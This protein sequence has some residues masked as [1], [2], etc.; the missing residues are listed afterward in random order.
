[1]AASTHNNRPPPPADDD[2]INSSQ[3]LLVNVSWRSVRQKPKR[4]G[5]FK[6]HAIAASTAAPQMMD[7]KHEKLNMKIEQ[8]KQFNVL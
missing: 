3:L 5:A 7:K 6:F 4:L 2:S 1:M 8:A